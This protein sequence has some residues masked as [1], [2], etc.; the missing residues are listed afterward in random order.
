MCIMVF[1]E[2]LMKRFLFLLGE[3]GSPSRMDLLTHRKD[4]RT[5]S[6][7]LQKPAIAKL[8]DLQVKNISLKSFK[9]PG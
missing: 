6:I 2:T 8:S 7:P 1:L 5:W 9:W 3:N 4:K